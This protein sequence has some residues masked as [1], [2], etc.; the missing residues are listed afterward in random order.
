MQQARELFGEWPSSD[1]LIST[2]RTQV[3]SSGRFLA[4]EMEVPRYYLQD[5]V[6]AWQW[7]Q[8]YWFYYTDKQGRQLSGQDAYKAA[9]AEGYFDLV[10]LRYGPNAALDYA[11]DKGLKSG[12]SYELIARIPEDTGYGPGFYWVWRKRSTAQ[13]NVGPSAI[14]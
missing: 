8:L 3:R 10:V 1:L 14:F 4:E 11:I 13:E 12:D 6:S 2:L 9:I 7:N 5:I